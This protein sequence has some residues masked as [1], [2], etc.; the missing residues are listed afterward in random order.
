MLSLPLH[1]QTL[2]TDISQ[3]QLLQ[4]EEENKLQEALLA[5]SEGKLPVRVSATAVNGPDASLLKYGETD[6]RRKPKSE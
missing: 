4:Q 3:L 6:R 2:G 5:V 1:R